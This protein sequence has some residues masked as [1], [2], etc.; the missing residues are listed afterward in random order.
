M[1]IDNNLNRDA[2]VVG[3]CQYDDPSLNLEQLET[4]VN[5]AERLAHLLETKGGF[6][7]KRLPC[8]PE[9]HLNLKDRVE[10]R[11]LENAI[12]N[13]FYPSDQ[14]S[15]GVALFFFVG[16]GLSKETKVSKE[17]F[18]ATSEVDDKNVHGIPYQWLAKILCD[19]SVKQQIVFIETCHSGAFLEAI[20]EEK[21]KGGFKNKD[22]CFITSSRG[23]EE[24]IAQ[25]VLIADLLEILTHNN[26]NNY[27]LDTGLKQ[28]DNQRQKEGHQGWQRPQIKNE[29]TPILITEKAHHENDKVEVVN[30]NKLMP[31]LIIL[32]LIFVIIFV[33]NIFSLKN[34]QK[35]ISPASENKIIL[36]STTIIG[37]ATNPQAIL[38]IEEMGEIAKESIS[39][40]NQHTI[41][42]KTIIK[43]FV[44]FTSQIKLL[45]AS[46]VVINKPTQKAEWI[47]KFNLPMEY[48]TYN[49]IVS[50]PTNQYVAEKEKERLSKE[51][52][53]VNFT[54]HNTEN[55]ER[56]N[57]RLAIYIGHGLTQEQAKKLVSWA[58]KVGIAKDA[59]F[60]IQDIWNKPSLIASLERDTS[61]QNIWNTPSSPEAIEKPIQTN[62]IEI[63]E[64]TSNKL[65][66]ISEDFPTIRELWKKMYHRPLQPNTWNVIVKSIRV[67][68]NNKDKANEESQ[69]NISKLSQTYLNVYFDSYI[70]KDGKGKYLH[71]VIYIGSGLTQAEAK[72]LE[73][74]AIE[75]GIAS[76]AFIYKNND[77]HQEDDSEEN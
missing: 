58:R 2:L 29:G 20:K 52:P 39:K 46:G 11:D 75:K 59:Y 40:I 4:L 74:W 56:K 28:R 50:S 44:P 38:L 71:F 5:Q 63:I 49:V 24:A 60:V 27:T 77:E 10:R 66:L 9:M 33:S 3:I 76:D 67:K 16:H 45:K 73:L 32:L 8:T 7:V 69:Y 65:P 54:L 23:H 34:D 43:P 26:I 61:T 14:S 48:G 53:Y 15:T 55:N 17:S 62:P 64:G 70:T 13:L 22:T 42:P 68:S 57:K 12:E 36:P 19:S 51:Y 72:K 35:N 18:L 41:E 47:A 1:S 25:S 31:L 30:K 37:S 6:K 21:E